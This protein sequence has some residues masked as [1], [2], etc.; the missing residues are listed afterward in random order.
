[1]EIAVSATKHHGVIVIGGGTAGSAAGIA[2]ARMGA[3]VLVIEREAALGGSCTMAQ[4]TPMMGVGLEGNPDTSGL[5]AEIKRRMRETGDCD[6]WMQNDGIFNPEKLKFVLE[7]MAAEA[8]CKLLYNT[9]FLTAEVHNGAVTGV[10]THN[11]DGF[12]RY[13]A[14]VFIDGTADAV[15][16]LAAGV[17]CEEGHDG[18]NQQMS[19]RFMM[20]GIDDQAVY[21]HLKEMDLWC[22]PNGIEFASLWSYKNSKLTDMLR[23]GVDD[24]EIEYSDGV[25]IQAFS[26]P[27]L[28][29]VFSFNCPE[30]YQLYAANDAACVTQVITRC[31]AAAG[32]LAAFF[33]KHLRGFEKSFI[34]ATAS[35]PGIRESRR[36]KGRYVV[37]YHD[38]NNRARFDDAI[39]QTAYPIDI[40]GWGEG[41]LV[42]EMKKGEFMEIPYRCLLA[43]EVD[44]LLVTGRCLSA[45]FLAQ[46]ALRI[47]PTCRA[48]GE[49]AG[50]AAAM[51]VRDGVKV[52]DI[53]GASVKQAMIDAGGV[54]VG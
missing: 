7:E 40:H 25:Y 14:D 26:V 35:M 12:T 21:A 20:G 19:L 2:A 3:D 38:Y 31:R 18:R 32:R 28:E 27:G 11:R 49:A 36:I 4:V 41:D 54:F 24:G 50:I 39:A 44:N 8:G 1:M 17:E 16:A 15:V 46:S 9:Q 43:K 51:S 45:D 53:G 42:R 30:A 33:K 37:T 47:Q 34:M 6:T 23:K 10:I 29:G 22:L 13:T 48:T 5:N 52:C